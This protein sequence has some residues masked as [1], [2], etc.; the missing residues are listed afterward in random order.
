MTNN[1]TSLQGRIEEWLRTELV[2]A[3]PQKVINHA[4]D[5]VRDALARIKDLEGKLGDVV[6]T[7]ERISKAKADRLDH[8][9]DVVIIERCAG[10]A[11]RTL[12]RLSEK[13][14]WE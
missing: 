5:L 6:E 8:R 4:T 10:A 12:S 2:M 1:P 7:L 14:K 11:Q 13:P 3:D 9:L